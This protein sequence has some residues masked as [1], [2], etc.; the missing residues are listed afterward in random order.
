MA[1]LVEIL[2]PT[3]GKDGTRYERALLKALVQ[4]VSVVCGGVTTH[5]CSTGTRSEQDA[6]ETFQNDVMTIDVIVDRLDKT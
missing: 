3:H 5:M 1:Y 4:E 2:V 6:E